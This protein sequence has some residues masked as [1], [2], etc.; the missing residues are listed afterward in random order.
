ML[1]RERQRQHEAIFM[2]SLKKLDIEKSLTDLNEN[3]KYFDLLVLY[4]GLCLKKEEDPRRLDY[5][6]SLVNSQNG[7]VELLNFL[8]NRLADLQDQQILLG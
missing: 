3:T 2:R 5:V 8:F 6:E 1:T 7:N 4:V